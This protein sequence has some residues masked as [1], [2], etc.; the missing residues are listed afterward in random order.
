MRIPFTISDESIAVFLTGKMYTIPNSDVSF[1]EVKEHLKGSN[2]DVDVLKD[3]LDK[4]KMLVRVSAGLV[5]TDGHN[6]YYDGQPVHNSLTNKLLDLLEDGFDVKPWARFM[7]NLMQNP[8]YNSRECLY[9]FLDHFK[10]PITEDGC[11][12][13][14]KRVR[15]NYKDVHTGTM[16]NTPGTVVSMPRYKVDDNP[17]NTCSS[18]LHACADEYLKGFATGAN[19]RT[20]AVKINPADVVAV[21]ADYSFSK[22]RVCEYYVLGDVDDKQVETLRDSDYVDY[23]DY[24]HWPSMHGYND[25]DQ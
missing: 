2:H 13:A 4:P 16:D 1:E 11:F 19:Y 3:L 21:P 24:D 23:D 8:S 12:I 6:V 14:F 15:Q 10:A 20:V 18:G 17:N 25:Y 5:T 9:N 22:M 7:D